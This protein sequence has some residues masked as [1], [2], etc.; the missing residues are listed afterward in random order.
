MCTQARVLQ[1]AST[2]VQY[3]TVQYAWPKYKT[4]LRR[5]GSLWEPAEL[6]NECSRCRWEAGGVMFCS[7]RKE[8]ETAALG[9]GAG[10][11]V[12]IERGGWWEKITREYQWMRGKRQLRVREGERDAARVLHF[13][14]FYLYLRHT[15][16]A[17]WSRD[18]GRGEGRGMWSVE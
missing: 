5:G 10:D 15:P 12:E 14:V 3:S 7:A 8:D 4:V 11:A 2:T 17:Q 1:C 13:A 9:A 6:G 16:A 18:P